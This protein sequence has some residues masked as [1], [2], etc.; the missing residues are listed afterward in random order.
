MKKT[1]IYQ[2]H[3]KYSGLAIG[4][5]VK[6]GKRWKFTNSICQLKSPH[7]WLKTIKE[8]KIWAELLWDTKQASKILKNLIRGYGKR[9]EIARR[10]PSSVES[11]FSGLNRKTKNWARAS[12]CLEEMQRNSLTLLG[13]GTNRKC[14]T[15]LLTSQTKMKNATEQSDWPTPDGLIMNS[16]NSKMAW[17]C[18]ARTGH[19]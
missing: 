4:R 13:R 17:S 19:A 2:K 8:L 1:S 5:P 12:S 3:K 11:R 16:L 18:L 10:Q 14:S 6:S 7:M 15:A 9:K